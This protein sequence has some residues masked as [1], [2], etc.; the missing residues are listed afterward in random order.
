MP[1]R[2][3]TPFR[4]VQDKS[5]CDP[6]QQGTTEILRHGP[7][8]PGTLLRKGVVETWDTRNLYLEGHVLLMSL[9]D[10]GFVMKHTNLEEWVA[11]HSISFF[12]SGTRLNSFHHQSFAYLMVVMEE[13]A[14]AQDVGMAA[15]SLMTMQGMQ[16]PVLSHLIA[17]LVVLNQEEKPVIGLVEQIRRGLALRLMQA[18]GS[19]QPGALKG[20]L[21]AHQLRKILLYIEENLEKSLTIEDLATLIALSPTHFAR[22]FRESTGQPPHRYI[23]A[24]RLDR[25]RDA[26][27]HPGVTLA[28][29]ATRYGFS[30]HSHFTRLFK[31][32]FGITPSSYRRL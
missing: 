26:L 7:D 22:A 3:P 2:P 25:S 28:E 9:Q 6:L 11:P 30:D 20:G 24:L 29:V 27:Q 19:S 5:P 1:S 14:F 32:R 31:D 4:S 15:P 12:P 18:A 23:T 21:A 17:S 16:D 10:S 8:W 13:T